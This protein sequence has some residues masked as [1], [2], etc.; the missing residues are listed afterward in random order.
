M[1][2]IYL[3]LHHGKAPYWLLNRMKKLA[4]PIITLIIQEYGERE[5]FRRI[6]DPIFFQ[7]FSNV[8][9]FDWNSSGVTTVMTGVL[10][11]V[12]NDSEFEIRVAG[13]KGK[14]AIATPEDIQRFCDE[15]DISADELITASR[16]AAKVDNVALQDGYTLYHHAV[17]FSPRHFTIIQQGMNER[18]RLARRYH[19]NPHDEIPEISEVH[20]GIAA[21]RKE[22]EV[23]NLVSDKS[24]EC[25]KTI[26][27][28][29]ND[30]TFKRDYSKLISITRYKEGLA[31]P[32]RIDWKAVETAYQLQPERFEDLLLIKGLGKGAVRALA[33]ISDLIYND[34]FDRHDPAKYSFALGG[35]DGVPFPVDRKSYDEVIQFMNE[36]VRQ[37]DLQSFQKTELLKKL[38]V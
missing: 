6:S 26:L 29:V 33:L 2:S 14:N 8:L 35:K 24:D 30:R 17:I 27:D 5:F 18:E 28:V 22:K 32:K 12:L 31:V 21:E 15:L 7:S 16:Y 25:R 9:G 3:P 23:V 37:S 10:K 4:K 13:G 34:H 1:P 11:S 36:V 19:W 20:S 38:R